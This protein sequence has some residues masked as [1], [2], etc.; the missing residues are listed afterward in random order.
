MMSDYDEFL[1]SKIQIAE[2]C[3][4]DVETTDL[5]PSLLDHQRLMVQWSLAQGRSLLAASFGL[6]KTRVQCEIARQLT[7]VTGRP[8]LIICP[9]GVKHQFQEE[10]GRD[11]GQDWQYVRTDDEVRA[12]T[13]QYL[14]T[15]YER[16]RDG[17]IDPRLHD[18]AG[19]SLDEGAVLRSLG[20]KTFQ[21]FSELFADTPYR[22][23]ATATP[24]PNRYIEIIN[25][26]DF[27]GVMDRGQSLTRWFKRDSTKAGNLTLHPHHEES[28]WK[29]V[30]S[31]ALFVYRPSDL[32]CDDTGYDLPPMNVHWH[33]IPTNH[34]LAWAET[35]NR[36][37]HRLLQDSTSS[38]SAASREKRASLDGRL[39]KLQE[40]MAEHPEQHYLIWH[41][42]EVER[43]AL[44]RTLPDAV[45]VY[46]TQDLEEREAAVLGFTRGEYPVLATKPSVAGVGCNF[47]RHCHTAIF[48]GIDDKF[49]DMIQAIHRLV[50]F[51]QDQE[52]DIHIIYT[53]SEEAVVRRIKTKW[54]QHERLTETMQRVVRKYGLSHAALRHD[55]TRKIG[56]GRMETN[57]Q[58]FR[59]VHNDCIQ[60][61][62]CMESD[63]IGLIVTSIP[64]G[65]L[66][67]YSIQ[68][69]DLGH[70]S[71]AAQ[72]WRQMDFLIPELLRVTMPGR[73]AAIHVKDRQMYGHQ[74]ASGVMEV[75][76]F[77]DEC[78]AAFRKHGWLYQ[79]R[80][81][82]VT[83]VV[84]ENNQTYR[85]GWT[86]MTKDASKMSSGMPEYLLL[87]R[88]APSETSSQYA[89][90]PVA[91]SKSEYSRGR[92]QID[93]HSLWRSNGNRPLTPDE[94]AAMMPDAAS[95]LFASEQISEAYDHER[96]VA[97]CEALDDRGCLPASFM[98]LPPR[99]T[100]DER[101]MVWDDVSYIHTLNGGQSRRR[102]EQHICPLPIDIAERAIRLYSNPNEIVLDPFAGLFTVPYV[103]VKMG[104]IGHGV[105]LNHDYYTAGVRY[106]EQAEIEVSSPTLFD[107]QQ[108]Q[109]A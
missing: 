100:A 88:K 28:F 20:S 24:S 19:V 31:W 84:R 25:Y 92:W 3:G 30:A 27:L 91:K 87:F 46:G 57:G 45:T 63:S 16:I 68:Y 11:L 1:R 74:S 56:V 21:V 10:D 8:F 39:M 80:R 47:Q 105:E 32:G 53:E 14:I 108:Y 98:L 71:D 6:G 4:I 101:D 2:R 83:D 29:W 73:V 93:A 13:S 26:A 49:H 43:K 17:G 44:E 72:F 107:L 67:E 18:F 69:E 41:H 52:V 58:R 104:R 65:N 86:E 66:Y 79:G 12:A 60:E 96:H 59:A 89:D 33:R 97:I 51:Q 15:N 99:V 70:S 78:V 38:I 94:I 95:R 37:Q 85:L 36:G 23:V 9:L 42:L 54:R 55:L 103:A 35:D 61:M 77:S 34:E 7:V 40:I 76:P 90:L 102:A 62:G 82:I 48:L 81:T 106:C 5:H 109:V 75:A 50:R 64:F 22:F